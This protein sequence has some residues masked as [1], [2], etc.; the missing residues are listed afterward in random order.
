MSSKYTKDYQEQK[1]CCGKGRYYTHNNLFKYASQNQKENC[2]Q[3]SPLNES[4]GEY[5]KENYCGKNCQS[6]NATTYYK[7]PKV[8]C[9]CCKGSTNKDCWIGVM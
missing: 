3:S 9:T 6:P 7:V 2:A 4:L 1:Q 5:V 8:D